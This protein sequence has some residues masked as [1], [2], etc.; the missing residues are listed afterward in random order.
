[1]GRICQPDFRHTHNGTPVLNARIAI[2]DSKKSAIIDIV[3]WDAMSE[4]AQTLIDFDSRPNIAIEGSLQ[5]DKWENA[6]GQPRTKLSVK[7]ERFY[8][9]AD[10]RMPVDNNH[11]GFQSGELVEYSDG[12]NPGRRVISKI[13]KIGKRKEN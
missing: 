2:A 13:R 6:K 11:T 7:V 1:V 8:V 9:L 12:D 3:F 10:I 4:R 5:Q